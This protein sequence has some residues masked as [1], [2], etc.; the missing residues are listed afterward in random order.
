MKKF[1]KVSVVTVLFLT[2][3]FSAQR[4]QAAIPAAI[5]AVIKAAV[6]KVIKAIDLQ[7]QRQQNKVIWLQ[8]AQKV[9]ENSLSKLKLDEISDWTAKQKEQY[10]QYFD[11]LK[12]VKSAITYY[13]RVKDITTKQVRLVEEYNRAWNLLRKDKNFSTD[14]LGY[15]EKVY[16]GILAESVRNVDQIAT[17]LKSFTLEMSDAKRLELINE[18]AE[19]V[20]QNFDDLMQFNTQNIMLGLQK[21]KTKDE[22]KSIKKWYGIE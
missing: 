6:V 12:K 13:Q 7:I 9:L 1:L 17:V 3:S 2:L 20:E 14:E 10:Q 11:E 5:I 21:A 18:S 22:V 4:T 8:N 19:K 16:S 15:M